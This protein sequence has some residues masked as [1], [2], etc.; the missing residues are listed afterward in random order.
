MPDPAAAHARRGAAFTFD[1]QSFLQFVRNLC[2]PLTA[3]SRTLHAPSF[4]HSKKDPVENDI[5]VTP[6]AR[7]V[8]FEGNYLS[9][10]WGEWKEASDLMDEL[11]FVEVSFEEA[12]KRLIKRHVEAGIVNDEEAAGKRADDN[13]L[14]NGQEIVEGR[15]EV[16]EIIFSVEDE[17]C[18]IS[19]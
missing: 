17:A 1:V 4:D 18:R 16:H 9:L 11:W 14:I 6:S 3:E 5:H 19:Q 2:K 7:V 15:V 8:I 12:R 13:D 10:A